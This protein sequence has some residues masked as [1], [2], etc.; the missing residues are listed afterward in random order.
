[1]RVNAAAVRELETVT[2][3]LAAEAARLAAGAPS[4]RVDY[5][6]GGSARIAVDGRVLADGE[7]LR[8]V[9]PVELHIPGIGHITIT[10]AASRERETAAA[11]ARRC[12]ERRLA[13]LA[14]MHV[15]DLE[16]ARAALADRQAREQALSGAEARLSGL[17]GAGDAEKGLAALAARIANLK[18]RL[19]AEPGAGETAVSA[20]RED[21]AAVLAAAREN[22]RVQ[23]TAIA[24]CVGERA[25][26]RVE[27]A[28]LEADLKRD[29]DAHADIEARLPP[30]AVRV[31]ER[32]RRAGI[33][34]T[35]A[36]E[37]REAQAAVAALAQHA[38]D[39]A[40]FARLEDAARL[41]G[42]AEAEVVSRAT[43]LRE[44]VALL[45]GEQRNADEAGIGTRV[46]A[47]EGELQRA[48][49]EVQRFSREI[50]ELELISEVL[51][52]AEAET[53]DNLLA[54]VV[55]RVAP[56]LGLVLPE[57]S[58][59]FGAGFAPLNLQRT[60][61]GEV[62][63]VL[64]RGTQEQLAILI[65]L[66]FGRLLAESGHAVPL[67]LDDALVYSDDERIARMFAALQLA[68]QSHQVI[69]LT[70]RAAVF[71]GLGGTRLKLTPW[72]PK[73]AA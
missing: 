55:Q 44:E 69:V 10:P 18:Q 20:S 53:R 32:A 26:L 40:A 62:M 9:G 71:S 46:T 24:T 4:V 63:G 16:A 31:E 42:V 57:A 64:S 13:L 12:E 38:P 60:G 5:I 73:A 35:A 39:A 17:A 29:T 3:D 66:G 23:A 54:P 22:V 58:V 70:C 56:Y 27:L 6:S 48:D 8:A 37:A 19:D 50:A 47:L 15:P 41:A 7:E 33:A 59:G 36:S 34:A 21:C 2:R 61:V 28:A 30:M 52:N 43:R 45:E 25:R 1:M 11:A 49:A 14:A 72:A 67:V 68:A 65:R 51:A